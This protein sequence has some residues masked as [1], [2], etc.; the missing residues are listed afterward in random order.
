MRVK[1]IQLFE[2]SQLKFIETFKKKYK[3]IK[4]TY[5]LNGEYISMNLNSSNHLFVFHE[6]CNY[7]EHKFKHTVKCF[8]S[9]KS[10]ENGNELKVLDMVKFESNLIDKNYD[11]IWNK[12]YRA[13]FFDVDV[14]QF[15]Y[16]SNETFKVYRIKSNYNSSDY[17]YFYSLYS[18]PFKLTESILWDLTFNDDSVIRVCVSFNR[19][20]VGG[21]EVLKS[22][23]NAHQFYEKL[24]TIDCK[25]YLNIIRSLLR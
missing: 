12:L 6:I 20:S 7:I 23:G 24:K 8:N 10:F 4:L 22:G 9:N 19:S 3:E 18:F 2:D 13:V 21:C 5:T 17:F 15:H 25:E 14:I 16:N 11:L 1:L